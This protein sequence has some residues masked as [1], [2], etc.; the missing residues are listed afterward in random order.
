MTV[1]YTGGSKSAAYRM[2]I[3]FYHHVTNF[4]RLNF[5]ALPATIKEAFDFLESKVNSSE[6]VVL[7]SEEF[8]TFTSEPWST[9]CF[10]WVWGSTCMF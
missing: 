10:D 4:S 3:P 8:S 1:G 6:I 7:S 2:A 9:S 5:S